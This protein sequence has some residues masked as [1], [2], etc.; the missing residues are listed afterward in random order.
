MALRDQKTRHAKSHSF[1]LRAEFLTVIFL[2]LKGY[3]ILARRYK[4]GLGEIDIVAKHKN[5]LVFVEVKAR[6]DLS[7]AL[8]SLTQN[9]KQRI[10]QAAL[11]YISRHPQYSD[12][13]MRFDFI[14]FKPPFSFEHI[15]NAW[16]SSS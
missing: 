4:C 5:A 9:A 11:H 10:E 12:D 8:Q 13:Q 3:R 15:D 6:Q 16:V 7:T 14:A 2:K 1:G